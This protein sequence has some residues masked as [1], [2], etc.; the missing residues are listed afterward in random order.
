MQERIL[1]IDLSQPKGSL[2]LFQGGDLLCEKEL[3]KP[4][5]HSEGLLDLLDEALREQSWK[6]AAIDRF[7][8][9]AGPGSFTGLRIAFATLKAFAISMKKPL[10]TVDASEARAL[11]WVNQA[12]EIPSTVAVITRISAGSYIQ[13]LFSVEENKTVRL[14]KETTE[15]E[16]QW[17]EGIVFLV[18]SSFADPLPKSAIR[19]PLTAAQLG[20]ALPKSKSRSVSKEIE[21]LVVLAPKYFGQSRFNDPVA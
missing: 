17:N 1:S 10:E 11:A 20:Q 7:L 8:T 5:K 9:T 15:T 4:Y 21:E 18:D 14:S 16:I 3:S 2:A 19:F 12:A 13:A 6:L